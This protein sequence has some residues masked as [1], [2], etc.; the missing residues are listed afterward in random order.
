L[1]THNLNVT[2]YVS[3]M[4]GD[5]PGI[6]AAVD[7]SYLTISGNTHGVNTGGYTSL[8]ISGGA[9]SPQAFELYNGTNR[10]WYANYDGSTVQQGNCYAA[11]YPGPSDARIKKNVQPWAARGL[12][13]I[14]AL[15]I[16]SFEYNGRGG[17]SDDGVTRYGVI[18]Q[19]VQAHLPEAVHVM[20][21][22]AAP[23]GAS[24]PDE[25][26]DQLA[27]DSDTLLFTVVNA[28]KEISARLNALETRA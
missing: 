8:V 15:D 19:D 6:R 12:A 27:F 1:I 20:P 23:I 9:R 16:V 18:A 14:V 13:E 2:G 11:A 7:N 17:M 5:G 25:V 24:L 3:A 26:P 22:S 28:L 4:A 10:F 21:A